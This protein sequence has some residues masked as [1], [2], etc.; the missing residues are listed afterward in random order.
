MAMSAKRWSRLTL[1]VSVVISAVLLFAPT[2]S[3]ASCE[4]VAGGPEICTTG[5]ESLLEN[6]GIGVAPILAFPVLIVAVPVVFPRRAVAIAAAVVLSA[7]TLLGAASIG[8]F[9]LPAAVLSW[10]AVA[11]RGR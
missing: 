11:A 8:L 10:F 5:R 9:L 6:Q 1:A 4:A 3:T 7:L 2:H